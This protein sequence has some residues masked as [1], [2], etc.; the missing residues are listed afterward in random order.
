MCTDCEEIT[1]PTGDTGAQGLPGIAGPQG[2]Q[3]LQGITGATGPQ[4]IQGLTGLTGIQGIQGIQG[5]IG[6]QG[7]QGN[8]GT[9][10]TNGTS[11]WV[12][13]GYISAKGADVPINTTFNDE[14][15]G[16]PSNGVYLAEITVN[17]HAK[18]G[19]SFT[20]Q[21]TKNTINQSLN[22]TYENIENSWSNGTTAEYKTFI[23]RATIVANM[24]DTIGFNRIS[25][26]VYSVYNGIIT[27]TKIV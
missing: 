10:G 5:P 23:H 14:S 19:A 21:L 4:G 2:I 12:Y 3:G 16:V 9:N 20:S 1:I 15:S 22:P 24:G 25:S 7:I 27:V 6:P 8:P 18:S 26:N 17:L 13:S 11:P